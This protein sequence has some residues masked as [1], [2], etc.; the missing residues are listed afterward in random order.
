MWW[1]N[2]R[3]LNKIKTTQFNEKY[4]NKSLFLA[5][6]H[7]D[8]DLN[9]VQKDTTFS[10]RHIRSLIEL[11]ATLENNSNKNLSFKGKYYKNDHHGSVPLISEYDAL[12]YIF[13]SYELNIKQE[14]F[15]NPEFDILSKLN[16][17]YKELSKVFGK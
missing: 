13:N 5:I 17:H 1:N 7:K 14:D 15:L 10:T 4:N 3:L 9:T 12:R 8:I 2:Q 6:A 11:N 16:N